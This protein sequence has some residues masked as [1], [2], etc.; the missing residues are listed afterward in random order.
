MLNIPVSYKSFFKFF[1][2]DRSVKFYN[3]NVLFGV[4]IQ[5]ELPQGSILSPLL[6]NFYIRKIVFQIS[7][8]C[9][10]IQFADDIA[11]LSRGRNPNLVTEQ[12][13]RTFYSLFEWSSLIFHSKS[14][15]LSILFFIKLENFIFPNQLIYITRTF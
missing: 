15:K 13:K 6:F 2:Y 12:F 4:R 11:V 14:I 9:S 8:N 1:L 10:M 5:K 7:H 3:N